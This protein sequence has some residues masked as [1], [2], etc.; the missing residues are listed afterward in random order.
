MKRTTTV[1]LCLA[2]GLVFACGLRGAEQTPTLEEALKAVRTFRQGDSHGPVYVVREAVYAATADESKRAAIEARLLDLLK[3]PQS[4]YRCR[5][6]VCHDWLPVVGSERAVPVLLDVLDGERQSILAIKALEQIPVPEAEAALRK[7]VGRTSGN[8]RIMAVKAL[9]ARRDAKAVD[10]LADLL[11]DA[12][13]GLREEVLHAIATIGT[14]DAADVL[15]DVDPKSA[16]A[17]EALQTLAQRRLEEDAPADVERIG[18]LLLKKEQP[19]HVRMAGLSAI[20]ELGSERALPHLISAIKGSDRAPAGHA[21]NLALKKHRDD[22][23]SAIGNALPALSGE[24]KE[25]VLH[26]VGLDGDSPYAPVVASMT[27]GQPEQVRAAAVRA[28][29]H[30]GTASHV[31]ALLDLAADEKGAVQQAAREALS[32]IDAAQASRAVVERMEG[33]KPEVRAEAIKAAVAR[34]LKG[35]KDRLADLADSPNAA[36]RLAAYRGFEELCGKGDA[37]AALGLLLEA[38]ESSEERSVA[39][40]AL[41]RALAATPQRAKV[42]NKM[43]QKLDSADTGTVAALLKVIPEFPGE[44]ALE[45]VKN[46]LDSSDA[47]VREAA[48]RSLTEWTGADAGDTLMEIVRYS[49]SQKHRTLALRGLIGTL[50]NSSNPADLFSRIRPHVERTAE[51]RLLLSAASNADPSSGLLGEILPMLE[52]EAVAREA[53]AA[54]LNLATKASYVNPELLRE[55]VTRIK[56]AGLQNKLK[57]QMQ[58]IQKRAKE[59]EQSV[60]QSMNQIETVSPNGF[61]RVAFLNC[62]ADRRVSGSGVTISQLTGQSHT[63]GGQPITLQT[64]AWHGNSLEY[65]ITGLSPDKDYMLGF[66]WWDVDRNGRVQSVSFGSGRRGEWT[67]VLPP[68]PVMANYKGKPT[69]ARVVLPI[70]SEFADD[71]RMRV[72]FRKHGESNVTVSEMWLLE[73]TGAEPE[74]RVAVVT[75]DDIAGHHWRTVSAEVARILRKDDR[76]QVSIQETPYLYASPLVDYWDA[77]VLCFQNDHMKT[78]PDIWSGLRDHVSEG[79]GLVLVHFACG[80]FQEWEDFVKVAGRVWNPDLRAHDPRGKFTVNISDADHSITEGLSDFQTFDELYT[81]LD[82]D[83]SIEVLAT[84]TSKVDNKKYPMAFT[85]TFGDGSVFH[86]T[87]GHDL[88]AFEAEE[89][90][91][92]YLR[93]LA[94]TLGLDQ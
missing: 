15:L 33:G 91:R 5:K 23:V 40:Q 17:A 22:A 6:L 19:L 85:N 14:D 64:V 73:R 20:A 62:G 69:W 70:R 86:C 60:Q 51:K 7:A 56:S 13:G 48:L 50:P 11:D 74:K 2:I 44:G 82:G 65:K 94:W 89:V 8:A 66:A 77:T 68:S 83:T 58:Q 49:K 45:Q 31:D 54:V 36:V 90:G 21:L 24:R 84:A 32:I 34:Q 61:R 27:K 59:L 53:A 76:L 93:G 52:D 10:L 67:E 55:A 26:Y 71:G 79:A 35:L 87:L 3:D 57:K 25:L 4:T 16:G 78:G 12:E 30:V 38:T 63:Y 41:R 75:G 43:V 92:L 9:G 39:T 46:L 81:C 18:R 28:L 72:A 1:I 42:A 88:R 47:Q 37:E 80:A 29:G